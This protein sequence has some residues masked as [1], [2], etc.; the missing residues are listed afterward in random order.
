MVRF[1]WG[2]FSLLVDSHLLSV[3]SHVILSKLFLTAMPSW[4]LHPQG[5]PK[6]PSPNTIT[7][8]VSVVT[9][10]FGGDTIQS[11]AENFFMHVLSRVRFFATPWPVACQ[12][13]LSIYRIFQAR[14]LGVGCHF[15]LQRMFLI[16]WSNWH[17]LSLLHYRLTVD[18]SR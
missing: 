16:Q 14:I 9:Y 7:L 6:A 8:G 2:F 4:S 18:S 12:V 3:S 17:P 10:A 1:R 11:T 5:L 13:P 15:L